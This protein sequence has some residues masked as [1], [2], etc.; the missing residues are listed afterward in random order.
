MV[1]VIGVCSPY[2]PFP[3]IIKRNKHLFRHISTVLDVGCGDGR[4]VRFFL[5]NYDNVTDYIAIEP[6]EE[7]I[8]KIGIKD[9]RLTVIRSLWECLRSTLS[10]RRFDVVI[11][12]DVL[13][14]M[15]LRGIY[16]VDD[17]LKASMVLLSEMIG[18]TD[19]YFLFSL[20]P[21]KSGFISRRDFKRILHFLDT[22][23]NLRLMDKKYLNRLY[24][25]AHSKIPLREPPPHL[26]D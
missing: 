9:P 10:K 25:T 15:D 13:M 22:H 11:L 26:I 4:F 19:K 18:M 12:W 23:P 24:I 1:S 7:L 8:K 14:F 16:G 6:S 3:V 20:H 17:H 2:K 5:N 21:V